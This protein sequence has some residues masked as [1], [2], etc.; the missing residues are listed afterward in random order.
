[1]LGA[2]AVKAI[3]TLAIT[4]KKNEVISRAKARGS[5]RKLALQNSLNRCNQ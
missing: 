2:A 3:Q 5:E 4:V 1:M